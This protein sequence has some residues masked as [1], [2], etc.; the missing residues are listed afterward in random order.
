MKRLNNL[1]NKIYN[2][3]NLILAESK[4]RKGKLKQYG[5]RKFDKNK[6]DLLINLHHILLN[7]EYKTS[8]Y[9]KF[10]IKDK[11]K[12]R[13]I[14]KLPYYSDR[15]T[16]WAIIN[17]LEHIFVESFTKD[18]Y[19]CIKGRGIT[20]CLDNLNKSLEDVYN[21]QYCLK[22]DIKKF[23][24]SI[25]NEILKK[26]LRKKFKDIELLNLLDE[27]I[28]SSV[29]LPIGNLCSQW[30]A[31]FYLNYFDHYIKEELKIKDYFRYCDD[32]V[33]FGNNKEDLHIIIR[34][35]IDYLKVNLD[36][37]LSKWQIFPV[38]SRGVDFLGQISYHECI[39][40]R[41]SIK[42]DFIKMIK[43][44]KNTKSIASYK[45]W[46]DYGNCINLK[47]KYLK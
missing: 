40:L 28:D 34:K 36:L 35:I 14:Y 16:H 13:E 38:Y 7:N 33:I 11:R 30:L 43:Y 1:Y 46:L 24:P 42:K 31:N 19:S 4:A 2:I 6:N 23:Y 3:D 25:N 27:I 5:V 39:Y 22:L 29:G 44:N 9:T 21:T 26:L 17:V 8:E 37:Q 10:I 15:I 20:Q 45:G 18:T 41:N 32:I 47:N 12:L